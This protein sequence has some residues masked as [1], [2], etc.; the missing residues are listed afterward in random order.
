M[1]PITDRVTEAESS[2]PQRGQ[3]LRKDVR[4]HCYYSLRCNNRYF[5]ISRMQLKDEQQVGCWKSAECR[6]QPLYRGE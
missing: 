1:C 4:T 2:T 5:R 3:A 6:Q